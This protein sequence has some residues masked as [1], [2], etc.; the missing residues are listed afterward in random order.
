MIIKT[1]FQKALLFLRRP[2]SLIPS[3]S[4][5]LS[6]YCSEIAAAALRS[7]VRALA[8]R[9]AHHRYTPAVETAAQH[10]DGQLCDHRSGHALERNSPDGAAASR[11]LAGGGQHGKR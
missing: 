3:L 5:S 11:L 9:L 2:L 10:R 7:G 4:L 1:N 6:L 8:A